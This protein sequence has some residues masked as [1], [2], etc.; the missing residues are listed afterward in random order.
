M[1]AVVGWYVDLS[2]NHACEYYFKETL[3][4]LRDLCGAYN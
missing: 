1:L 3:P 4:E 2:E